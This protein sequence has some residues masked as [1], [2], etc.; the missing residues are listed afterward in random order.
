[1][2]FPYGTYVMVPQYRGVAFFVGG[3]SDSNTARLIMVGDDR[4]H[5]FDWDD[6]ERLARERHGSERAVALHGELR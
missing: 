5:E 3:K 6:V 1:M 4:V 2:K